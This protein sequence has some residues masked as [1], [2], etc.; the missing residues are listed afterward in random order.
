MSMIKRR[1]VSAGNFTRGRRSVS[2]QYKPCAT[3]QNYIAN[4]TALGVEYCVVNCTCASA[5][6][7]R[8]NLFPTQSQAPVQSDNGDRMFSCISS[9]ISNCSASRFSPS[10]PLS[11]EYQ[12]LSGILAWQNAVN[13]PSREQKGSLAARYSKK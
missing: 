11:D 4:R 3:S 9:V 6:V 5:Y 13:S 7:Q 8:C 10:Y 1:Q 2:L 12:L